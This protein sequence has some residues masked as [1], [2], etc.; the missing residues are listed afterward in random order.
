MRRF[1][2][3]LAATMLPQ[4]PSNPAERPVLVAVVIEHDLP[5]RTCGYN[6]RGLS[7]RGECPECQ[8]PVQRAM[9]GDVLWN[10]DPRWVRTLA[11]GLRLL[12]LVILPGLACML[13]VTLFAPALRRAWI[14]PA[15]LLLVG[16]AGMIGVWLTTA[17]EPAAEEHEPLLSVRRML[18]AVALA[19]VLSAAFSDWLATHWPGHT[20]VIRITVAALCMAVGY[21]SFRYALSIARRIPGSDL[22]SETRAVMWGLIASYGLFLGLGAL[23]MSGAPLSPA[24]SM[25]FGLSCT[26]VVACLI[27]TLWTPA[28]IG[29]YAAALERIVAESQ[30][31]P[32]RAGDG[33][34]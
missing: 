15:V 8:T 26:V 21:C 18:R 34:P 22:F 13:A 19:A 28:L 20:I 17:R 3:D 31:M 7:P 25:I 6:L 5:C 29:R 23:A 10:S 14:A 24:L 9:H 2:N 33:E 32:P 30:S 12:Q 27:F 1:V 4:P 16:A 11:R